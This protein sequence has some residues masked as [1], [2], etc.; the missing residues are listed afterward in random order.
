MKVTKAKSLNPNTIRFVLH[1]A[2]NTAT[3]LVIRLGW[4]C[5]PP[6][7]PHASLRIGSAVA[8]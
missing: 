5:C 4:D 3:P 1:A 8:L 6:V 2:D 7:F